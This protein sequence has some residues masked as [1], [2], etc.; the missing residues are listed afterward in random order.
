MIRTFFCS[1]VVKVLGSR[2]LHLEGVAA[3]TVTNH[4][5]F[6]AF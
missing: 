2:A 4:A 1:Q 5:R 3:E 6:T